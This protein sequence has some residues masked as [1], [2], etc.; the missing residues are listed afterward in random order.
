VFS[1]AEL[2][3]M[4]VRAIEAE[5]RVPTSDIV[6]LSKGAETDSGE[7]PDPALRFRV[8]QD[9]HP[10]RSRDQGRAKDSARFPERS[11]VS[12]CVTMTADD[13]D[14]REVRGTFNEI[15]VQRA[16]M[17]NRPCGR[18]ATTF[19]VAR[20][21]ARIPSSAFSFPNAARVTGFLDRLC[22]LPPAERME[23]NAH[24]PLA[25]AMIDCA[26]IYRRH[27][28]ATLFSQLYP[29]TVCP[30]K[31][32][33]TNPG[34]ARSLERALNCHLLRSESILTSAVSL[35]RR[36]EIQASSFGLFASSSPQ[37]VIA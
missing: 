34:E 13:D 6:F 14:W 19:A 18:A 17:N 3:E 33:T 36:S 35:S 9:R 2:A 4:Q 24:H 11:C 30:C 29:G 20:S 12:G 16:R 21:Q 1:R 5:H 28:D 26:A 23:R 8:P 22:R 10:L 25:G 7:S 37:L 31:R 32:E 15:P 27:P